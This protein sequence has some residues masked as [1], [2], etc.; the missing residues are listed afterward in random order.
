MEFFKPERNRVRVYTV[1]LYIIHDVN[2]EINVFTNNTVFNFRAK[3]NRQRGG[4]HKNHT[5]Y[6]T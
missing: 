6:S 3:K 2:E 5:G 4:F 1:G